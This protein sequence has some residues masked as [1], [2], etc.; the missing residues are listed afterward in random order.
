[1]SIRI[2]L[3]AAFALTLLGATSTAGQAQ[4]PAPAGQAQSPA[5]ITV[6]FYNAPLRDLIR[7]FA[8]YSG[9]TIVIRSDAGN[10]EI[11]A[12]FTNVDWRRALDEILGKHGFVSSDGPDGVI[13]IEKRKPEGDPSTKR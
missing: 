10:P 11:T 3:T 13:K 8:A 2:C 5:P 1:M 9:R 6:E 12:A 4:S 7:A